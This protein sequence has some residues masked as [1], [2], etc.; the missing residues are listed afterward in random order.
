MRRA[1][2]AILLIIAGWLLVSGLTVAWFDFGA[3]PVMTLTMLG[4]MALLCAPFLA[5]GIG[6]SPGN[7]LAE[8]GMT[9]MVCAGIGAVL[10]LTL[11]VTLSDPGFKQLMPPG[12]QLPQFRFAPVPGLATSLVLGAIGF[13]LW[14]SERERARRQRPELERIFGDD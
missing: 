6:V 11:V 9:F 7:R 1:V 13:G 10:G 12:Q 14:R 2:S 8:L 5:I 4:V 3:G